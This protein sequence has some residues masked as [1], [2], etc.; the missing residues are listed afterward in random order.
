M[1]HRARGADER[2]WGAPWDRAGRTARWGT[3]SADGH[4][5]RERRHMIEI[6]PS[7]AEGVRR[8]FGPA[9][10]RWLDDLPGVLRMLSSTWGLT[11]DGAAY[12]DARA[13]LVAPVHDREGRRLVLKVAPGRETVAREAGALAHWQGHGAVGV[14]AADTELGAVLIERCLPGTSLGESALEE[15]EREAVLATTLRRLRSAGPAA[16]GLPSVEDWASRLREPP[17]RARFSALAAICDEAGG[18]CVTLMGKPSGWSLLHGD[19]HSRNI[20]LA[21]P[22]EWVAI[23]PNPVRGPAAAELGAWL[24]NPRRRIT[25]GARGAAWQRARTLR[26]AHRVEADAREIGSWAFVMAALTAVWVHDDGGVEDDV[27]LWARCA[28]TLRDIRDG[29]PT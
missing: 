16:L 15:E 19:L 20:L 17:R 2:D 8:T 5:E 26:L 23:D 14:V 22:D 27:R 18:E 10:V 29:L 24:R 3:G 12:P 7:L 1:G 4:G 9:G 21:G 25:D 28:D 11:A 6:S 13:K